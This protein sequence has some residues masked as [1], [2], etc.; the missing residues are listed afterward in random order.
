MSCCFFFKCRNTVETR[1]LNRE[2]IQINNH[3][4][5]FEMCDY[6]LTCGNCLRVFNKDKRS[7]T[8]FGQVNQLGINI[9]SFSVKLIIMADHYVLN[10]CLVLCFT[11]DLHVVLISLFSLPSHTQLAVITFEADHQRVQLHGKLAEAEARLTDMQHT[12]QEKVCWL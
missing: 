6:Q 3:K 8:K 2:D 5:H 1:Y 4:W 9:T 7:D 12:A 11:V 10:R